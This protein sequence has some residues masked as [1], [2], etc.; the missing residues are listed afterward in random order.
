MGDV[1]AAIEVLRD[2]IG[3]EAPAVAVVLGSGLGALADE[4]EDAVRIPYGDVPGFPAT[5]VVG[6]LGEFVVGGLEGRRVVLQAGRFHLYEGHSPQLVVRPVRLLAELGVA[7]LVVTNAAGG[8][9]PTFR[10][11][12]LMMIADHVNL[13]WRNPL[14]GPVGEGEQRFPD[15]SNPYDAD[16]RAKTRRVAVE[17]GVRLEEGV[18]AGVLG[19]NYETP[20]EIRML[21]RVGADAVGMSTVPEVIT[22]A[23]RGMRCLGIST[24]TNLAAGISPTKLDHDEVLAAGASAARSLADLVRGVVKAL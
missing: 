16:L 5:T 17:R 10:P 3:A 6:H 4:V 11:P 9:R 21:A 13:M 8:I 18:Y 23:A 2:R 19:P 22:A 7:T 24:I 15:M 20:S 12:L 1:S 14:V